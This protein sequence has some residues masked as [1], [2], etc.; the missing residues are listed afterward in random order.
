M[1][2][3]YLLG[4]TSPLDQSSINTWCLEYP[5]YIGLVLFV[6]DLLPISKRYG[7]PLCLAFGPEGF[8][9]T[10]LLLFLIS[11]LK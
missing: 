9:I 10:L 6:V 2:S 7:L 11:N 4:N 5:A 3:T 1:C 8:G